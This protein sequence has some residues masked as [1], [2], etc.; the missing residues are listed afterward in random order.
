MD[1]VRGRSLSRR[2]EADGAEL[3]KSAAF[4][5]AAL[6]KQDPRCAL[7][8]LCSATLARVLSTLRPRHMSTVFEEGTAV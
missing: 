4:V 8:R 6:C 1:D 2:T 7:C 3:R 5:M